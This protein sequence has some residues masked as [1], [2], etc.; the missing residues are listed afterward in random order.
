MQA[1]LTKEE[2][3]KLRAERVR[4]LMFNHY[5]GEIAIDPYVFLC[6]AYLALMEEVEKERKE[7]IKWQRIRTPTHG[8]CCT[9]QGCGLHYDECRCDLDE[10]VDELDKLKADNQA[11]RARLSRTTTYEPPKKGKPLPYA[12]EEGEE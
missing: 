9:C 6:D 11:L 4:D 2:V 5:Q 1:H 10:V 7:R 8:T 12:I 3:E